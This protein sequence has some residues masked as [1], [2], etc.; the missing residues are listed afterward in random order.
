LNSFGV[1]EV[2]ALF[3]QVVHNSSQSLQL[4]RSTQQ[5]NRND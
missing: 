2:A 5:G 3:K 4:M 1:F